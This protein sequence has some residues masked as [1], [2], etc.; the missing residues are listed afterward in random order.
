MPVRLPI[1][2]PNRTGGHPPCA[3][4][5]LT[6][7]ARRAFTLVELLIVVVILG[8][9]AAVVIPQFSDASDDARLSAL[10]ENLAVIRK[11]IDIYKIQH[12]GRLPELDKFTDQMTSKTDVTGKPIGGG[13][14]GPYL[15]AIPLNPFSNPPSNEV[16]NDSPSIKNAWYYDES[17]GEF[18]ALDGGKT[19]G[20][21]HDGL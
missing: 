18:K 21:A 1:C 4:R 8:I 3:G 12:Q 15:Q 14:F 13:K 7:A 2:R 5:R 20:V 17:T 11:Q 10:Q 9:L 6:G 19:N 16:K